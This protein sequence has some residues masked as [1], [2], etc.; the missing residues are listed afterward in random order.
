MADFYHDLNDNTSGNLSFH[1][2]LKNHLL[3]TAKWA[4]FL[5]IVGFIFVGLIVILA[6]GMGTIM[7]NAFDNL[8]ENNP[9][10]A[11][12]QG[13]MGVGITILYLLFALLYF[14]PTL[15][16]YQFSSRIKL[17][18]YNEQEI[19]FT[20]AFSR[21]KSFFKF[22]G[23]LFIIILGFYALGLIALIIGVMAGR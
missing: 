16:L 4:K 21:L 8:P 15:Y 6:F 23:I 1:P 19:D 20:F 17:A 18:L 14:F 12:F 2:E 13:G 3:E 5:S 9:A 11:M 7:S 22:W 10:A